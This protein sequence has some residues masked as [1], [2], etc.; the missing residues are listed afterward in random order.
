MS[1]SNLPCYTFRIIRIKSHW[2]FSLMHFYFWNVKNNGFSLY[3]DPTINYF[4]LVLWR[5]TVFII[6]L[7]FFMHFNYSFWLSLLTSSAQFCNRRWRVL[8][9]I[10]F[11]ESLMNCSSWT[12]Y[13]NHKSRVTRIKIF[14]HLEWFLKSSINP[15]FLNSSVFLKTH[16]IYY[17]KMLS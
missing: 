12:V 9:Q 4:I 11:W 6:F 10:L 7:K 17:H 5:K 3:C 15:Q 1:I 2:I 16:K 14:H 13:K 8:F